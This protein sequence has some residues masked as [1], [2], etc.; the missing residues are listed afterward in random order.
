MIAAGGLLLLSAVG[1]TVAWRALRALT[2]AEPG[3]PDD[4]NSDGLTV[5]VPARNEA[6]NLP[7]LLHSLRGSNLRD[8]VVVDDHSGDGTA[9]VA[10]SFGVQV[11]PSHDLP[12]GW[13]GKPW[14]CQQGAQHASGDLLLF[15]DADTELS[16]AL[17][18]RAVR[19]ARTGAGLVSV[20]PTHEAVS[21]WEKLQGA[22]QLLLLV[23]TPIREAERGNGA[24]SERLFCIGQFLL[25][26]RGVYEAL[27]GHTGV[28]ARIAED[29]AFARAVRRAG[30]G[31]QLIVQPHGLRVRM[32]PDG[33][34]SFIAG[35]RRNFREGFRAAS[36]RGTLE[37]GAVVG[38]L[39]SA[40]L[41]IALG[42]WR[43]DTWSVGVGALSY[44]SAVLLVARLQR[45]VGNFPTWSAALY[46]LPV[47]LFT[48]VSLLAL[49]DQ[50]TGRP[51]E[52]RGRR[53]ALAQP[54][55][56]HV[57]VSP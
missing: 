49:R 3:A 57:R 40:P 31:Y 41:G 39:L 7:K 46:P 9:E 43:G 16:A 5:I 23:A 10:R 53:F 32:Y 56:H 27:G 25:F 20:V 34:R 12:E 26:R 24:A 6:H 45:C 51:V 42:W 30:L 52:W 2:A 38:F 44:V 47:L 19:E 48:W 17:I 29:L 28:R 33:L 55:D 22:F 13:L 50:I 14:A 36:L 1:A 37:V 35:W 11:V 18:H 21:W 15:T 8:V 4:G 54:R